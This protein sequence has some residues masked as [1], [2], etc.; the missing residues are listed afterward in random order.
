MFTPFVLAGA[1]EVGEVASPGY[2]DTTTFTVTSIEENEEGFRTVKATAEGL[3]MTYY[4][5]LTYSTAEGSKEIP[6][7]RLGV[8]EN[9]METIPQNYIIKEQSNIP[10][11]PSPAIS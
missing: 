7:L 3:P 9:E 2:T 4:A 1:Q 10:I 5:E 8:T 11:I 6:V